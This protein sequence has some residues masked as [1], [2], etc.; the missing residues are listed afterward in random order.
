MPK[1]KAEMRL[2][3]IRLSALGDVA[4]T[5]P[6]LSAFAKQHP[7]VELAVLSRPFTKP[8]FQ[9]LPIKFI[10]ADLNGRHKGVKGLKKLHSEITKDF[11]P[12]IIIDLHSVMRSW[13]LGTFFKLSGR[14]VFKIDKGR[15]E[16]KALT[17]SKNKALKQ[18]KHSTERYADVFE[19][20]GFLFEFNPNTIEH[21]K[22][23]SSEAGRFLEEIGNSEK[24]IGIA[25]FAFHKGKMWPIEKMKALI[26]DISNKGYTLLVFGGKED[27]KKLQ[28]LSNSLPNSYNVSAKFD[29]A[30]ELTL[31]SSLQLMIAMDSSNMHFATLV[32]TKVVSIWGATHHLAGFGPLGDNKQN[33]AE[34]SLDKLN[35][36]PCSVFGNKPC[37]RGDY[38]CLEWLDTEDVIEKVDLALQPQN[39]L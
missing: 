26:K 27:F 37:Y 32:G 25:P 30:G 38:A 18:L 29:L 7:N 21:L 14:P 5:V 15:A 33:I 11:Q 35:C 8:L 22:Y 28:A 2:L 31:I 17:Q 1:I 20:A 36:R 6:V 23:E 12:D 19:L 13:I 24:L 10:S 39:T 34:V 4:L 9:P 3:I 16:K